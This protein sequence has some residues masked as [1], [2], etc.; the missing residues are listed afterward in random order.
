MNVVS[1]EMTADEENVKHTEVMT[2]DS[3]SRPV[4][5]LPLVQAILEILVITEIEEGAM[6]KDVTNVRSWEYYPR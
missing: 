4:E 6:I 1:R 3:H 2:S 5:I